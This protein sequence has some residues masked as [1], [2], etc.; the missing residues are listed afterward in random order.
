M[1]EE[2]ARLPEAGVDVDQLAREDR[3]ME[4]PGVG[5][6]IDEKVKEFL[7]T[8]KSEW[9][10][11]RRRDF[12]RVSYDQLVDVF[13][14]RHDPTTLNRQGPDR[15]TQYRSAIFYHDDEQRRL[16]EAAK[17]RWSRSGR[18]RSPIVTEIAPAST[19]YRAEE[20]HQRYLE[21]HGLAS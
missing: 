7:A 4:V 20:Y 1:D 10:V 2:K 21:K 16:A 17:E 19:F 13:F 9:F 12:D 6:A 3:L 8:G 15:G 14:T 18:W 5:R 11:S